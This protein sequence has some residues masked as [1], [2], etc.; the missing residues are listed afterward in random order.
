MGIM[1]SMFG[2]A[3]GGLGASVATMANKY[4]DEDLAQQRAQ[5][6]ADI[7]LATAGKIRQADDD[8][9]NDPTR[10]A[11]DRATKR[12]DALAAGA[13]GREVEMAGLKDTGLQDAR[14]AAAAKTQ[15]FNR[16]EKVKDIQTLTPYEVGAERDKATA[17]EAVQTEAMK[18]RLP[19]EVQRAAQVAEATAKAQAKYRDGPQTAKERLASIEQ[20]LG[21]PLQEPEKLALLGLSKGGGET[22]TV[23]IT[24]EK[25]NADGSTTK[26]ERTEKRR[27]GQG[28]AGGDQLT[29]VA[30]ELAAGRKPAPGAKPAQP[31]AKP[32]NTAD[33]GISVVPAGYGTNSYRYRGKTY[34]SLG[35]AQAAKNAWDK[36]DP[37]DYFK[38]PL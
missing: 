35:E 13:T 15:E 18:A 31:A 3:L 20:V 14:H 16:G 27:A 26:T 9:K 38:T 10:I 25:M 34:N 28:G 7:Q 22:D 33:N 8:F 4:I 29:D 24:D 30:K 23:K 36:Q 17:R 12:E 21:R 5:A 1:G 11:R 19:L 6:M 32:E 37:M 2:R